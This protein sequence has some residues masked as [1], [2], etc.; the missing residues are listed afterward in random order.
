MQKYTMQ[1][2]NETTDVIFF[3]SAG[4]FIS[5]ESCPS[6]YRPGN[7]ARKYFQKLNDRPTL[8]PI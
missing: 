3:E 6:G 1:E 5:T 8:S 7:P 2:K 4:F